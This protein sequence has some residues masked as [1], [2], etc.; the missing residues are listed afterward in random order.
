MGKIHLPFTFTFI[1]LHL[2]KEG[3]EG[4]ESFVILFFMYIETRFYGFTYMANRKLSAV[5]HDIALMR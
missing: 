4:L 1:L 5:I 2:P 3:L